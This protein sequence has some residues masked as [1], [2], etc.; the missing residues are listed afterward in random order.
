MKKHMFSGLLVNMFF[1]S[2]H[3]D[4]FHAD[5]FQFKL[6]ST[7]EKLI[8]NSPKVVDVQSP[9]KEFILY[10]LGRKT[11]H[12]AFFLSYLTEDCSFTVRTTLEIWDAVILRF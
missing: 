3:K 5:F 10:D 9:S 8:T 1:T 2:Y 12:R 7:N 6:H 11:R 4:V